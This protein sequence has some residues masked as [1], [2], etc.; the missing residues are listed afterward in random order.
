MLDKEQNGTT[1][2]QRRGKGTTTVYG[3]LQCD[4]MGLGKTMQITATIVNHPQETTLL[5]AP[6]AMI[7]TWTEVCERAGLLVFHLLKGNWECVNS[8]ESLMDVRPHFTKMRPEVYITNYQKLYTQPFSFNET[9]DRIVLDEAHTIRN[10]DGNMAM[11]ARRLTASYRWAVTGT[12]LVNSLRDVVS[13]L[14][15]IGVPHSPLWRWEPHLV[16]ALPDLVIHRSLDSLRS[17]IKDAPPHPKVTELSLEFDTDKEEEFYYGIQGSTESMAIKYK[18]DQLS[19]TDA[20]KM[21]LRLRQLSVH[22][23]IYINAKRREDASYDR[24]NWYEPSTKMNAVA[25]IIRKD[26]GDDEVHRYILF[27]QFAEEMELFREFLLAENLMKAENI[28]QYDGSLTHAQRTEVLQ[29]SKETTEKAVL[30]LQIQAGGVGLNLQEY[31]R[32][33]FISPWWTAALRNQAVARAVRMG[34]KK[35]VHVYH[36]KL[37]VEEDEDIVSIDQLV[38]GKAE[39]KQ[40]MLDKLFALCEQTEEQTKEEK[41]AK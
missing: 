40:K 16:K 10:P 22:P 23:Q 32:I 29:R 6:L 12:P 18:K 34:Q 38:N 20:F 13:L 30:L 35:R 1:V 25:D 28:L 14:A 8:D 2:S 3:G 21:L 27:C 26:D 17:V 7:Q 33:I 11:W 19:M 41:S 31:D 9:W 37:A 5:L 4:D 36:L 24:K 15:F 39:E